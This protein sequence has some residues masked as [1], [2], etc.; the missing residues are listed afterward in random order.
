MD[1]LDNETIEQIKN[2]VND[3]KNNKTPLQKVKR[4]KKTKEIRPDI[5]EPEPEI[6]KIIEPVVEPVVVPVVVDEVKILKSTVKKIKPFI[7]VVKTEDD[8]PEVELQSDDDYKLELVIPEKKKKVQSE[9]QKEAFKILQAKRKEQLEKLKLIK[10]IEASKILLENDIPLKVKKS[11]KT[12]LNFDE[13]ATED[14]EES[15]EEEKPKKTPKTKKTVEKE[16]G[17]STRNKKS[18]KAIKTKSNDN[19]NMEPL[20]TIFF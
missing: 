4:T 8:K 19:I 10:K 17:T 15:E 14:S 9:K 11:P 2:I 5:F 20:Q 3:A 13:D 1:T 16:W 6:P 7:P 12:T 18:I